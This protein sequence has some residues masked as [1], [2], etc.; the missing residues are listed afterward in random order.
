LKLK[1]KTMGEPLICP[2][3]GKGT[4]KWV[5]PDREDL[6]ENGTMKC[7]KCGKEFKGFPEWL[8]AKGMSDATI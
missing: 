2:N 3:C 6:F 4:M 5:D 7:V 1:D 8:K